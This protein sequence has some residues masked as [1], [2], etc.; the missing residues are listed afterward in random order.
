M[1]STFTNRTSN[2]IYRFLAQSFVTSGFSDEPIFNHPGHPDHTSSVHGDTEIPNSLEKDSEGGSIFENLLHQFDLVDDGIDPAFSFSATSSLDSYQMSEFDAAGQEIPIQNTSASLSFPDSFDLS[3]QAFLDGT[4]PEALSLS[5]MDRWRNSPPEMEAAHL[6]DIM[7][8]VAQSNN[9]ESPSLQRL[10]SNASISQRRK[11]RHRPPTPSIA[12]SESSA[13]SSSASSVHSFGSN[14]SGSFGKFYVGKSTRRRRRNPRKNSPTSQ[15]WAKKQPQQRP[16]QCT[17]CTDTFKSKHDW[18]RHEK[19]LHLSLE[20]W[21]CAPFGPIYQ[22]E[23]SHLDR[24]VFC[25]IESPSE[26]HIQGHRYKECQDKPVALRTFYRKDHLSQH[27]R[28][29]HSS[30]NAVAGIAKWKSEVTHINSRCGFCSQTF[31]LWSDRNDHLAAHF[32]QGTL[33]K[34]WKGCRGLDP[35]VALAV[36]NAMPPY[37]IGIE[38]T[39]IDPFS[40]SRRKG[41]CRNVS[42]IQSVESAVATAEDIRPTPFEQLTEHL[43][44]FVREKQE[45]GIPITDEA[46][47]Q[48]A[49][50]FVYGEDDPWNQTAADSPDW[51]SFFKDGM[52]LG[53][54]CVMN[55][56]AAHHPNPI[57]HLPWDINTGEWR[58]AEELGSGCGLNSIVSAESWKPW[59][60]QSPECLAEF[61]R[62]NR[63]SGACPNTSKNTAC[64]FAQPSE[65]HTS[66]GL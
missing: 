11:Q 8:S 54:A 2:R 49:R 59:G 6:T 65:A 40:A 35:A 43:I 34:E 38:S 50:V 16:F 25:D 58:D 12:A 62:F 61:R 45:F 42:E 41:T 66:T 4:N 10:A 64:L 32:R 15:I 21:V 46:I 5:P 30:E 22:D 55:V 36:D 37:L 31:T 27:L 26:E 44:R 52:G 48:E 60:W 56:D 9:T 57:F 47:Q 13:S 23:I 18:T 28:L 51:L 29:V 20:S 7:N 53:S 3:T 39:G 63:D 33:I 24:C 19:T 1:N 17:F 14:H